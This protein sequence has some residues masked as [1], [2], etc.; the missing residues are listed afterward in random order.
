MKINGKIELYT[1]FGSKD[2]KLVLEDNNLV[3]DGAGEIIVNMLT[4]TPSLSGVASA[5]SILDTSNYT[6]QAMSFGKDKEGYKYH[7]HT[8]TWSGLDYIIGK[9]GYLKGTYSD[10]NIHP[11]SGAMVFV[12]SNNNPPGGVS[13]YFPSGAHYNILPSFPSPLDKKLETRSD[14]I[15]SDMLE[16]PASYGLGQIQILLLALGRNLNSVGVPN[17][18]KGA[19]SDIGA[20]GHNVNVL[21]ESALASNVA[22]GISDGETAAGVAGLQPV[23]ALGLLAGAYPR[24]FDSTKPHNGGTPAGIF[25]NVS[26][27]DGNANASA[28]FYG[29]FNAAS[30]MDINGYLGKVFNPYGVV[31][32]GV[33]FSNHKQIDQSGILVSA[34][35]NFSSTGE[36]VYQTVIGSG[37]LGFTNLYGGI[38]NIGLW[39]LDIKSSLEAGNA[40]PYIFDQID[41][42]RQYKLF[43]KKSF[44][45][46]LAEIADKG[47]TMGTDSGIEN[48]KDLTLIWRLY[49]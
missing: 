8:D 41:N 5:S 24:K 34:N 6:I 43:S 18:S 11:F 19:F 16:I 28:V 37:D 22:A 26:Q 31:G 45:T 13:S 48:Y 38:Y 21:C 36:V 49:F 17:E 39:A 25:D 4:T 1:D 40:P 23:W 35:A 9:Y 7:A 27:V 15:Y 44:T 46:N 12:S 29:G 10:P 2:Q 30:S 20:I 47:T 32:S 42:P 33:T 14:T 3:V